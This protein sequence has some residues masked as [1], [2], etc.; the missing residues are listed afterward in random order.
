MSASL[1]ND[2]DDKLAALV[3]SD[4][5]T[6]SAY[7]TLKIATIQV[8]DKWD[9]DLHSS[10]LGDITLPAVFIVGR[11]WEPANLYGTA[12][13]GPH[14]DGTIHVD[15]KYPYDLVAATDPQTTYGAALD[16]AKELS[17]RFR[18]LFRTHYALGG[19]SATDTEHVVDVIIGRSVVEV[20]GHEGGMYIGGALL[21]IN[22][23]TEV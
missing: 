9:T 14:G 20:R 4:M 12:S 13:Q 15:I 2:I 8:V 21:P 3:L 23:Y 5:G 6:G 11:N 17:R 10:P 7:A 22:I 16:G 19:I 18:E 1:W